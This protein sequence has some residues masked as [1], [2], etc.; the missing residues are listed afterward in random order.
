MRIQANVAAI[1][2]HRQLGLNQGNQ[3]K[4][5]EKLSS[6]YRVNRAA[7]DAAGL[8]I[9]EK[10][11]TQIRGL[12]RASLNIQDGNSLL[13][14]ADGAL[15]GMTDM[16]QRMRELAVQAANDTNAPLDRDAIQLEINQLT[17]ELNV[18]VDQT[19]F[20]NRKLFDG[21]MVGTYMWNYGLRDAPMIEQR[22]PAQILANA[23][24]QE[25]RVPRGLQPSQT[26]SAT[27]GSYTGTAT[28]NT[29]IGQSHLNILNGPPPTFPKDGLF[30]IRIFDPEHAPGGINFILDFAVENADG[31]FRTSDFETYFQ[32]AFDAAF[33][34]P[35]SPPTRGATISTA[36]GQIN[37][38]THGL[39]GAGSS[40]RIGATNSIVGGSAGIPGNPVF[41][42]SAILG[43]SASNTQP[44]V[45]YRVVPSP[46]VILTPAQLTEINLNP[47]N[48]TFLW[49]L[50]PNDTK[51]VWQVQEYR[52]TSGLVTNQNNYVH[53]RNLHEI[54]MT[55]AD[56][57]AAVGAT[58]FAEAN[59]YLATQGD[60]YFHRLTLGDPSVFVDR[61]GSPFINFSPPAH[62]E[63][64]SI[65]RYPVNTP[66]FPHQYRL[67]FSPS[68]STNINVHAALPS[69]T[70]NYPVRIPQSGI[71]TISISGVPTSTTTTATRTIIIDFRDQIWATASQQDLVD[72]I[73]TQINAPGNWPVP[74]PVHTHSSYN[75]SRPVATASLGSGG[76]LVITAA[77]RSFG[78]SITERMSERPM[79]N[80]TRSISSGTNWNPVIN[81]RDDNNVII[82]AVPIAAND[83]NTIDDFIN[84]NRA[85]FSSRGFLLSNDAGKIKLT[86][87]N[88]GEHVTVG[89]ISITGSG[90]HDWNGV[91]SSFGLFSLPSGNYING[92][93][94]S[95]EAGDD[96][97]LWI[98]SGANRGDGIRIG[99]PRLN[100]QDLGLMLTVQDMSNPGGYFGISTA[101]GVSQYTNTAGVYIANSLTMGYALDVSSHEKASAALSIYT[102]AIN[103]LSIER[104]NIGAMSNRL[105]YAKAN[106]DNSQENLMAAESL[107][108]DSDM[109]KEMTTF[110]KEQLLTQSSTAM[111][112]QANALPQSVLQLLRS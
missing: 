64:G 72:H 91:M 79:Y 50:V 68:S 101:F 17:S 86:S 35:G 89:N 9:S 65:I 83:Y 84:A 61:Y 99:I 75:E 69:N 66:A 43:A 53:E 98:Q 104:A 3:A 15:Q 20:N 82:A 96:Y 67:G 10:M 39:G 41:A 52:Y 58:T 38:Q 77:E 30:V 18:M 23:P 19:T 105:D 26:I 90:G 47:A 4:S 22:D 11:R 6:G 88:A 34:T 5:T 63:T 106:V 12:G 76:Q 87:V 49:D 8:A 56:I 33:G 45:S 112:A 13:Q 93:T 78:I 107:I 103:I 21:S 48:S 92:A 55:K 28:P 25:V 110:I 24:F 32:N 85:A 36:G 71:L 44:A 94:Y 81:I 80:D 109:A 73:N 74:L 70:S 27:G 14:V 2:S 46:P 97:S 40:V 57:I 31:N 62:N 7:D 59:A 100:A 37:V 29:I 95:V 1:N 102:N 60:T 51:F 54:E 108:R 42:N 16:I 111:L